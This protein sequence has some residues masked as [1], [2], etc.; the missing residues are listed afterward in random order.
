MPVIM[1]GRY[2]G[3]GK[4][5][6][7]VA[8]RF[9]SS[10]TSR[11]VEGAIDGLLRHDVLESDVLIIWVPGAF[12]MPS[13]AKKAAASGKY[14]AVLCL[15]SVIR[16]ETPH[17]DFVASEVSKG[18]ASVGLESK[19]PVIYGV[20]TADTQEQALDRSGIKSGNKG[21]DA[22]LS[23]LEMANLYSEMG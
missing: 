21:F 12:E 13:V 4:K 14:D 18:I 10:I 22:A 23:A 11:L 15:G 9:N 5:F 20:I 6:A 3:K 19:I 1:E 16:G 2:F 17:F 8:S 7:L